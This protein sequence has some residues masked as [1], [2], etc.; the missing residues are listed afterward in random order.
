MALVSIFLTVIIAAAVLITGQAMDLTTCN[1]GLSPRDD[2]TIGFTVAWYVVRCWDLMLTE[3][4]LISCKTLKQ[5]VWPLYNFFLEGDGRI[6]QHW[7][8]M[9]LWSVSVLSTNETGMCRHK[10]LKPANKFLLEKSVTCKAGLIRFI[11]TENNIKTFIICSVRLF[12]WHFR[13][14]NLICFSRIFQSAGSHCC[15]RFLQ[16]HLYQHEQTI[17]WWKDWM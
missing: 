12:F 13:I 16:V 14:K 4:T 8:Q 1:C 5:Q 11:F 2:S 15:F 10:S 9:F 7:Q 6:R 17:W 3:F